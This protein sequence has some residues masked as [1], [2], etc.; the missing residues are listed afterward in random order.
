MRIDMR[1]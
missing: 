1:R